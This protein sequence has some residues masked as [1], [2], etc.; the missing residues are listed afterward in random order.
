ML[1]LPVGVRAAVHIHL[2]GIGGSGLSA[3]AVVLLE[4]GYT[5]SGSDQAAN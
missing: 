4:Q 2:L 3:I 5:V 1:N